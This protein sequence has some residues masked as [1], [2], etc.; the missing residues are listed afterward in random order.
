MDHISNK[1]IAPKISSK[2]RKNLI[3]LPEAIQQASGIY[4]FGRLLKSFVFSTDVA[5]LMYTDADAILAVYSFSPHPAII[6]AVS[7]VASVPVF[8]GVGGGTTNG[9]RSVDIA[10]FAEAAGVMGV[11]VNAP[12]SIEN[13]AA[14]E[15][16]VDSPII[17]TIVSAYSDIE[18]RLQAGVDILN[19]S[20]GKET[21]A[22][23]RRIREN[24]PDVPIIATGGKSKESI[25]EVIAAGANAVS[26]TPPSSGELFR[27]IMDKYRDERRQSFLETHEGMTLNQYAKIHTEDEVELELQKSEHLLDTSENDNT[28]Q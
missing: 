5:T 28:M 21:A 9:Q 24:Y 8:A 3:E 7:K 27:T 6:E 25:A 1:R 16:A 26:W 23:V 17:G 2:L 22:I 15:N 13:I 12:M 14:I 11:V 18:S 19:V 10:M 4:I 20:G